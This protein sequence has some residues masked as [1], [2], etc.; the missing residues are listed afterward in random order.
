M[1]GKRSSGKT[2]TAEL[3]AHALGEASL[4]TEA[5]SAIALLLLDHVDPRTAN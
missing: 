1:S 2:G 3:L 5:R 4:D